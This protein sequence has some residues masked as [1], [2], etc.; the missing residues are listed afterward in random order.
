M[1]EEKKAE[2]HVAE[3]KCGG[4]YQAFRI[5]QFAFALVP[6]VAGLDKFA[7]YL[8]NWSQYLSPQYLDIVQGYKQALMYAVGI[9]EIIAGLGIIFKPKYFAY[10][11]ALWL[12][13][14]IVNLFLLE[15][16]YDIALRDIGLF[17][18]AIALGRLSQHYT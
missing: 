16:F 18:A 15:N 1:Q 3:K 2:C 7:N 11:V 8:T 17:L 12:L 9:V 5:L 14:I 10:I 13:A 6:I 4:P